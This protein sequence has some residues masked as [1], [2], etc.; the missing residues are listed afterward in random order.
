VS[1]TVWVPSLKV[2]E[3]EAGTNGSKRRFG[4]LALVFAREVGCGPEELSVV[5]AY[6]DIPGLASL[7]LKKR[8]NPK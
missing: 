1:V 6:T 5:G 3:P 4:V 2:R 7:E 8:F